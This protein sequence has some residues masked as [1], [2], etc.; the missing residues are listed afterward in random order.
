[1][2]SNKVKDYVKNLE[3]L[4][5]ITINH[6]RLTRPSSSVGYPGGLIYISKNIPTIIVPDLHARGYFLSN[7]LDF[8]I[9]QDSILDLLKLN[10]IQVVCV[11]DG[12]H[13]E[14]RAKDRWLKAS[15][16]HANGFANHHY[17]DLEMNESLGV[18]KNVI[19]L[20]IDF[21]NNFFFLKGNH[22]NI[23]NEDG[24]GNYPFGKFTSE[25]MIV[26]DWVLKFYG[27]EF[28]MAYSKFE[29][30]LPLLAIGRNFLISHAEPQR[31]YSYDDILNFHDNPEVI[32]GLTWT[33]DDQSIKGTV[34]KMLNLF[35]GQKKQNNVYFTGH[36]S[37]SSL[38]KL[39][40]DSKLVQIHNPNL[41]NVIYISEKGDIN[42]DESI[43][44]VMDNG[45]ING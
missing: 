16:E 9:G 20:L 17:I 36:R 11:G 28:L 27:Q 26:K 2:F 29:K 4:E 8:K 45:D 40:A 7:L 15:E 12:F 1:M 13:A 10:A 34:D 6:D 32:Y 39:R 31:F 33:R 3:R 19:S 38:Y 37:I 30:Q 42:I 24:D 5:R 43:I 44:N 21:P 25:G 14:R 22:E 41:C 35:I 18:M 23:L